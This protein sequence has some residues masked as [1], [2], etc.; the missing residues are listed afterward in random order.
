MTDREAIL[1][2]QRAVLAALKAL[3]NEYDK[4]YGTLHGN[5]V[6]RLRVVVTST[7]KALG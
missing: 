5:A 7:L 2:A 4:R 1:D 6:A 3:E